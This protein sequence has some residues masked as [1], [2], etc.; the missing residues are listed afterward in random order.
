MYSLN[1]L[2]KIEHRCQNKSTNKISKMHSKKIYRKCNPSELNRS[3]S[4]PLKLQRT[5]SKFFRL[6]PTVKNSPKELFE[7]IVCYRYF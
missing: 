1:D 5:L 2:I 3:L 4:A 6:S 7:V